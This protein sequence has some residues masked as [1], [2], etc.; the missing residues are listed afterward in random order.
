MLK[1][2]DFA[3]K[4]RR[5]LIRFFRNFISPADE[6]CL[7]CREAPVNAGAAHRL[8]LCRRC[9]ASIPWIRPGNIRCKHCGRP[10]DCPDCPRRKNPQIV[11][12]RS[13]VRY[14]GAMKDWLSLYKYRGDERLLAVFARM[15]EG[16]FDRML[17][18]FRLRRE[19]IALVTHVPLSAER[20]EERGFNQA[21]RIARALAASRRLP[22]APLL[23]RTRHTGKQ[24]FKTRADRLSDLA[25]VFEP[26]PDAKDRIAGIPQP[27]I[28]LIDDVYTT[29][30][31]LNE[32]ART[33]RSIAP[34]AR[35][36]G[37]TWAR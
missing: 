10:E 14:D 23:R 37:L 12:N 30:S 36:Y 7:I 15:L 13:A 1:E 2:S 25:G 21:E 26:L 32:C 18:E 6:M 29:G 3:S 24:S 27:V 17:D 28:I 5:H 4:R 31:T 20:L 35:V 19:D 8:P 33:V 9:A 11:A 22:A 34:S 16:V